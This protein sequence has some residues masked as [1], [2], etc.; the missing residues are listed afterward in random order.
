MADRNDDNPINGKTA[1]QVESMFA[2]LLI[3]SMRQTLGGEGLFPGDK[4]DALGSMFD[5]YL[6]EEIAKG[7][8]IGLAHALESYSRNAEENSA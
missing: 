7:G 5:Q 4:S 1:E 6:G 3:K 8:G 2:S